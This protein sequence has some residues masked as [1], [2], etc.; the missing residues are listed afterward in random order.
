MRSVGDIALSPS[1]SVITD[2]KELKEA[3]DTNKQTIA[4]KTKKKTN[5]YEVNHVTFLTI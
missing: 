1:H 3:I 5:K 2:Q 4:K